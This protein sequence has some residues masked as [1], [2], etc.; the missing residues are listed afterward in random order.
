MLNFFKSIF[1]N[2]AFENLGATEFLSKFN[3]TPGA[4]LLD[5]R[6]PAEVADKKIN[7]ATNL[8]YYSPQFAEQ[9]AKL[10]RSKPYFVYCRSGQRSA[11]ACRQLHGL[12]FSQLYN[13][14]GGILALG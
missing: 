5:V 9:L 2:D 6:T 1:K 12:G 13:L 7:G 14:A 8:D 3:N 4:V 11:N 10:D